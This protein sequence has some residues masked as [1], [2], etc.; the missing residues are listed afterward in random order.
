LILSVV[1]LR[2]LGLFIVSFF[3]RIGY[4]WL[5]IPVPEQDTLDYQELA[6]NLLNGQG[7]VSRENWF[8]FP[9]YSWRP[10]VYPFFLASV[11]LMFGFDNTAVIIVQCLIGAFS[12]ILLW[13]M[14][15]RINARAAW[16]AAIFMAIYE[17]LVSACSEV[18]SETLFTFLIL[19]ALWAFGVKTKRSQFLALG[20]IAVGLCALTRPV[21]LLLLP[22]FAI[23]I[24]WQH[25]RSGWSIVAWVTLVVLLVICPWTL[26]NYQVHEAFVPISTHGG[27]IVAQSNNSDPA[28]RK[29]NGWGIE[30]EIFE[31]MPTEIERDRHWWAMG[32]S[33]IR[34][35]PFAY[36]Q[37]NLERMLRFFYFFRPSYNVFFAFIF[38]FFILGILNYGGHA[39]FKMHT[40]FI[41]I[42]VL[43]FCMLL[44]GS[45]RFRL[46]IEPLFIGFGATYIVENCIRWLKLR[47]FTLIY[48]LLHILIWFAQED[49]R[50]IVL[51]F[52]DKWGLK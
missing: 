51:S 47:L 48:I 32:L 44:Y 20:G 8:G 30:K 22:S 12:V 19:L 39:D 5:D 37:L 9:M 3:L 49:L 45:T 1:Q 24:F 35:N 40:T 41:A 38:P 23:T 43:V 31:N 17:P 36:M 34:E 2:L 15:F 52:L 7:F 27:F 6:K 25:G 28:W 14:I 11:Y 50:M 4:F 16:L 26:R 18:M 33:F 13:S 42:S 10:P 21:G 29:K 46:P